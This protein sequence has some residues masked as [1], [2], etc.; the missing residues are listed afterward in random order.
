MIIII[1]IITIIISIIII[2]GLLARGH[3]QLQLPR[4]VD[5]GRCGLLFLALAL[6]PGLRGGLL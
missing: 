2:S 6:A 4:L 3:V 1:I 5:A